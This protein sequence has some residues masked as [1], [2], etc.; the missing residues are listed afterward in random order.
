MW[1]GGKKSR[2]VK[3]FVA[4]CNSI[5]ETLFSDVEQAFERAMFQVCA[6]AHVAP[7]ILYCIC[8]IEIGTSVLIA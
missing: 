4:A 1:T 6:P 3:G 2:E 8:Y 5:S 7:I